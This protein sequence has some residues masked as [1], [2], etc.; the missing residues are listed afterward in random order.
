ML[1]ALTLHICS[2]C[3]SIGDIPKH[4]QLHHLTEVVGMCCC[5]AH[6][7][8]IRCSGADSPAGMSHQGP[9]QHCLAISDLYGGLIVL[10]HACAQYVG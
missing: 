8:Q 4:L 7:C 3:Q 10:L 6:A 2:I 5:R 1:C 9:C